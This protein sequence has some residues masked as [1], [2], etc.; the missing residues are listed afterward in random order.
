MTQLFFDPLGRTTKSH[1]LSVRLSVHTFQNLA[2][3]N[4]FQ[5]KTMF[6]TGEIVGLAE[7]IIT[8]LYFLFSQNAAQVTR[9]NGAL[10]C[11]QAKSFM[12]DKKD[13]IVRQDFAI[14]HICP[15]PS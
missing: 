8:W 10:L 4:K 2:E 9:K 5:V 1:M 6:T 11:K 13:S 12:I 15:M 14:V 7:W 3:Q